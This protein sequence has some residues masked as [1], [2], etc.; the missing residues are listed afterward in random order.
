MIAERLS[1]GLEFLDLGSLLLLRME[2]GQHRRIQIERRRLSQ[3]IES[4]PY[5]LAGAFRIVILE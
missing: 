5:E 1:P 2:I 3:I 4:G